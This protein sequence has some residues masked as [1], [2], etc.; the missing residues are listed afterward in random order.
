M[1]LQ[2]AIEIVRKLADGLH[3][4]TGQSLPTIPYISIRKQCGLCSALWMRWRSRTTAA[5]RATHCRRMQAS[6]GLTKRMHACQ[7][8]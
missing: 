4:E 2:E 1:E 7:K 6:H 5:E 3:P 8:N